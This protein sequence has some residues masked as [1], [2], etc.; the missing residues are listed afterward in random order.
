MHA[1]SI[2]LPSTSVNILDDIVQDFYTKFKPSLSRSRSES[3]LLQ[4]VL[5]LSSFQASSLVSNYPLLHERVQYTYGN[6][7]RNLD[8]PENHIFEFPKV[9]FLSYC[10]GNTPKLSSHQTVVNC[11]TTTKG[12]LFPSVTTLHNSPPIPPFVGKVVTPT[13]SM[14]NKFAPLALPPFLHDLP[15]NYSQRLR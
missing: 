9:D 4:Y 11:F 15:Q 8:E 2:F 10:T 14:A 1:K 7:L 13:I 3:E 6:Y 5:D 12:F